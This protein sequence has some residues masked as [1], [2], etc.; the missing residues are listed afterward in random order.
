MYLEGGRKT[1]KK[2]EEEEEENKAAAFS[3]LSGDL[4]KA[5]PDFFS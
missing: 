3:R 2:E 5:I 1:K 4:Q